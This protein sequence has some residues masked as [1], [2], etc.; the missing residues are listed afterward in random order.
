VAKTPGTKVPSAALQQG[1]LAELG[2]CPRHALP[3]VRTKKRSYY[4][5]A[6]AWAVLLIFLSLLIGLLVLVLIRKTVTGPVPDCST[7]VAE[8]KKRLTIAW[9]AALL[10]VGLLFA[11]FGQHNAGLVVAALVAIVG[12]MTYPVV[13][14]KKWPFGVVTEDGWW[15]ELKDTA[16]AFQEAVQQAIASAIPPPVTPPA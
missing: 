3:G 1:G 10:S 12:A 6:P 4:T 2:I 8:Q 11:S 15:V 14:P 13:A 9:S 7:C 5:A 16:P